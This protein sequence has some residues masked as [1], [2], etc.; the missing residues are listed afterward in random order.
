MEEE[1]SPEDKFSKLLVQEP[2]AR[3]PGRQG[4]AG[5]HC[6]P[7]GSCGWAPPSARSHPGHS[8]PGKMTDLVPQGAALALGPF[9]CGSYNK[10]GVD[11]QEGREAENMHMRI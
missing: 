7:P 1:G 3:Q 9:E 8:C 4:W 10:R 11:Q 6:C 2:P 5:G